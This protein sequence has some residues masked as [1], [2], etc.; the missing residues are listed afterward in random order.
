MP[1]RYSCINGQCVEDPAGSYTLQECQAVCEAPS[2]IPTW[3]Y[4]VPVGVIAL[5]IGLYLKKKG[6]I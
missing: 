6:K 5:G 2:K 1:I 3:L 4:A